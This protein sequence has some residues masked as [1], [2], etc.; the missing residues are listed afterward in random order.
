MSAKTLLSPVDYELQQLKTFVHELFPKPESLMFVVPESVQQRELRTMQQG[1]R[2]E[3]FFMIVDFVNLKI[4][5][6]AGLE[7]IGYNSAQFTFRQYLSIFPS[8]GMLQLIT[9]VGKQAFALSHQSV[10]SF[11]KP[12]YVSQ[13]PLTCAD[14]QVMLAKRMASPWQYTDTGKMTSYVVEYTVMKPYE[15]E[16][17]NPRFLN[18]GP[19]TETEFNDAN[20]RSFANMPAKANLFAPK[21]IVLMKLYI[22]EEHQGLSAKQLAGLAGVAHNTINTYNKAILSKAKTMFGEDIL[23]KT[24]RD[25]AVFLKKS[26]L[27]K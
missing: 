20:A 19:T 26:G 10:L 5:E 15:N 1:L 4:T 24:A 9:L 23:A 14:G 3:Q 13:V 25:V 21:E 6:A 11:M 22:A 18:Q 17:M 12:N 8:H 16:P 2:A 27:L 7:E